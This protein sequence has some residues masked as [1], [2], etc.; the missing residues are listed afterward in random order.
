MIK[1]K[2]YCLRGVKKQS[3]E[4]ELKNILNGKYFEKIKKVYSID[5]YNALLILVQIEEAK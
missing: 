5:S 2:P 4:I 1:C 3:S